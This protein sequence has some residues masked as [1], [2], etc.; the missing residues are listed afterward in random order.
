MAHEMY[1][2]TAEMKKEL[3]AIKAS[4]DMTA[5]RKKR[6][7]FRK[8]LGLHGKDDAPEAV[9]E[10]PAAAPAAP[11]EAAAPAAAPAEESPAQSSAAAETPKSSSGSYVRETEDGDT[12]TVV[13]D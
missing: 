2:Y 5:F 11:V 13:V 3:D 6:R 8:Q 7:E 9:D 1:A 10:A 12:I 4:G